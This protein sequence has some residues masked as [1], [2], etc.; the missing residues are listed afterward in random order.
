M[1]ARRDKESYVHP[2]SRSGKFDPL[3]DIQ[4]NHKFYMDLCDAIEEFADCAPDIDMALYKGVKITDARDIR[5][6]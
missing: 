3:D 4:K 1:N 5:T 6:F 2:G